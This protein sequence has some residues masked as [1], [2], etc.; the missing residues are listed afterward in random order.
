MTETEAEEHIR[1][2][3]GMADETVSLLLKMDKQLAQVTAENETLKQVFDLN[4][5]YAKK[6]AETAEAAV[7]KLTELLTRCRPA[8]V[9]AARLWLWERGVKAQALLTEID[10]VLG[11]KS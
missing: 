3:L 1:W 2:T 8:V 11:R 9:D 10:S 7:A 6:R 5:G 4:M